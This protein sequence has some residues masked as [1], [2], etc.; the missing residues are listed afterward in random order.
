VNNPALVIAIHG[1]RSAEGQAVGRALTQRVAA[2][3]SD[4]D[5]RDAYVELDTPTIAEQ[6]VP[7]FESGTWQGVRVARG[8]PDAIVQ[9]LNK[10]LIAVI[11]SADIRSRLAGQGAEVV[12]M[13]PAEEEQFFAKERARWAKVVSAANI[14]LD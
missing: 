12:T 7:G 13:T 3:L 8:T 6:G 10:E 4:V 11:R 9:R 14:K 2:M 5:V 1:T